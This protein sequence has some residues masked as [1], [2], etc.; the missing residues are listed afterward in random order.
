MAKCSD[1]GCET[2]RLTYTTTC[3]DLRQLLC[4]DCFRDSCVM[5]R[6]RLLGELAVAVLVFGAVCLALLTVWRMIHAD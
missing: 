2:T 3:K 6:F 4:E 5:E 1:C